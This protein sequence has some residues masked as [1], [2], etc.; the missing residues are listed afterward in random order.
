[1]APS[2][3][4]RVELRE[5]QRKAYGR[6][7]GLTDAEARRLREL[8]HVAA[9]AAPAAAAA[10]AETSTD[11]PLATKRS[12]ADGATVTEELGLPDVDTAAGSAVPSVEGVSVSRE[13]VED[14][15]GGAGHVRAILRTQW[16]LLTAA[17]VVL[18]AIGVGAGWALFG[19]RSDDI[20]LNEAQQQRKLELYEKGGYDEGSVRAIGQDDDALVW[21]GTRNDGEN[22]CLVLDVGAETGQNCQRSDDLGANTFG[23]SA[24]TMIPG[25][26]DSPAAS[27]L[28][29]LMY[30]TAGVPLVSIQRWDQSNGVVEQFAGEDRARAEELMDGAEV[31]NLTIVGYFRDQPVW[32]LD[33]WNGDGAETCLIVD[34]AAGQSTC[35][36]N[37]DALSDG[38]AVYVSD[39]E[40]VPGEE[41]DTLTIWS[42][43]V[44]YTP[45]QTPY[46]TIIRD[47]ESVS[48]T[49]DGDMWI[50][51]SKIELG[52]E[53]GD[54]IEVVP[55]T[56]DSTG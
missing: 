36:P 28:A 40:V 3:S 7:G 30:S 15:R 9:P 49:T 52:G 43:E 21:Y 6:D 33:R 2:K 29:Y 5:L 55:P 1:M 53:Y 23:L 27:V 8:E 20:P 35:R 13:R 26:G 46:L 38:I 42:L 34:G 54:P 19:N 17:A 22:V 45:S 39:D 47:P 41:I 51:G 18:L 56:T 14:A 10:P 32:L 44:G 50:D 25:E 24:M 48:V 16:R 37:D 12:L 11:A 4:E 31:M